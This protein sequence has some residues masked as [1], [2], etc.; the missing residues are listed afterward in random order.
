MIDFSNI[1]KERRY[2]INQKNK[3]YEGL[4]EFNGFKGASKSRGNFYVEHFKKQVE[5]TENDTYYLKFLCLLN[6]YIQ[7]GNFSV[8]ESIYIL[9]NFID[10]ELKMLEIYE[11]FCK[12]DEISSL[13]KEEFG[14]YDKNVINL[15]RVYAK[16]YKKA[17]DYVFEKNLK[18]K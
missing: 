1:E 14:F 18:I 9:V 10:P 13:I 17:D 3:Y 5:M 8:A 4:R 12:K 11:T 6:E 7:N 15:E 2:F 16:R